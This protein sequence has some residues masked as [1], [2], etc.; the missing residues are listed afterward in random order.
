MNEINFFAAAVKVLKPDTIDAMN[1]ICEVRYH[2][3]FKNFISFLVEYENRR[4]SY[5]VYYEDIDI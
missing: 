1:I 2:N 5:I 3:I 4:S